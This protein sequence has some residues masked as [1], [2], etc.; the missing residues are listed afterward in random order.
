MKDPGNVKKVQENRGTF[1]T[2]IV[3]VNRERCGK[4]KG[5]KQ[6][7]VVAVVREERE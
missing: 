7:K 5:V 2:R 3:A 1:T 6:V 4:K